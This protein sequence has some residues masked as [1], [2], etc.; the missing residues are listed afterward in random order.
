MD[1]DKDYVPVKVEKNPKTRKLILEV[2]DHLTIFQ[3]LSYD[4]KEAIMLCMT[5]VRTPTGDNLIVQG[6]TGNAFY[7][8]ESGQFNIFFS[9]GSRIICKDEVGDKFYMMK[10]GAVRCA[11]IGRQPKAVGYVDLGKGAHFGSAP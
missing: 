6:E 1:V 11:N 2:L 8:V 10:E 3:E 4:Q 5:E 7:I 9:V